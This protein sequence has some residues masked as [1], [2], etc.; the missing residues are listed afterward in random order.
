MLSFPDPPTFDE[1]PSDF[2]KLFNVFELKS[3][4]LLSVVHHE[5]HSHA[6]SL[7][8][9]A[10]RIYRTAATGKNAGLDMTL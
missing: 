3:H 1:T 2:S 8:R 7:L 9:G 4:C 5:R 10:D 6:F